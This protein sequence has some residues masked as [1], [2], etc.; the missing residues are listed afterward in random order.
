VAIRKI[1]QTRTPELWTVAFSLV[2][3]LVAVAILAILLALGVP[4]IFSALQRGERVQA[5][6]A[7]RSLGLGINLYSADHSGKFVGPL[8]PGQ[9]TEYDR[10]RAGRLV[11]E[12]ANYLDIEDRTPPYVVN[13][14]LSPSARRVLPGV[15]PKDIRAYVMNMAVPVSGGV[16]SPWGSL[17]AQPPSEPLPGSV[18]SGASGRTWALSEAYQSHPAV[19][20]AAWRMNT[21]PRPVHG[22]EPLGLF[23]D[24]SVSF[25]DPTK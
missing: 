16:L 22:N 3:I 25:F 4:A 23:F 9:V 18:L 11:R 13:R 5:M 19:S 14:F 20:A 6:S 2:E 12:L 10:G 8:W 1:L 24:G 21:P 17:A 15:A 7:M